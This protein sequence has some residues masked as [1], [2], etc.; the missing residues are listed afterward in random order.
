M[1]YK[2]SAHKDR[3]NALINIEKAI[4][5]WMTKFEKVAERIEVLVIWTLRRKKFLSKKIK[6]LKNWFSGYEEAPLWLHF[7]RLI[8]AVSTLAFIVSFFGP[9]ILSG[10]VIG[11]WMYE[12]WAL[13]SAGLPYIVLVVVTATLA[14]ISGIPASLYEKERMKRT[15]NEA[16]R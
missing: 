12:H 15:E 9:A 4:F 10:D 13:T 16:E 2:D 8:F 11:F 3:Y 5:K 1:K 7:C 6:R 14:V